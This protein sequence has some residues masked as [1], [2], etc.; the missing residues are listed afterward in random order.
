M[1]NRRHLAAEMAE[2]IN[3]KKACYLGRVSTLGQAKDSRHGLRSQRRAAYDYAQRNDLE[4]TA[5]YEDTISGVK[6]SREAFYR[7][8]AEADQY[9]AVIVYHLDRIGRDARVSH[10]M[11]HALRQAGLE[12]HTTNRGLVADDL[13]TDMEIAISAEER[14]SILKRTQA[15]LVAQARRGLLPNGI[16]TY[17]YT[18][19]SGTGRAAINPQEAPTVRRVFG[20]AGDGHGYRAIG[21][22]LNEAG[23]PSPNGAQWSHT[24]AAVI[25][26]NTAYKGE[27]QWRHR[28]GT[29]VI[30]VP[31]IITPE[32]WEKAQSKR[33]GPSP[34]LGFPLTGHLRCGLCGMAMSARLRRRYY[35]KKDGS[36]SEY[37]PYRYYRCN[38]RN[39]PQ[40]HC[41]QGIPYAPRV[42]RLVDAELR[43]LLSS[44][45]TI[46]DIVQLTRQSAPVDTRRLDELKAQ[47]E[48]LLEALRLGG[49][50]PEEFTSLRTEIREEMRALREPQEDGETPVEMIMEAARTLP[51][52]ELLEYANAV[53]VYTREEIRVTARL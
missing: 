9:Q 34:K 17:G 40:G 23:V 45:A 13:M 32:V 44:D 46:R 41:G 10:N 19:L 24:A 52:A 21:R 16:K 7:L 27:Y 51:L 5:D 42:E 35:R 29:Y 53:A 30:P 6:E 48:R 49:L 28:T 15:G 11:I 43:R 39:M 25:I 18:N 12:I 37:P 38:S 8:L 50:T 26:R 2:K 22:M 47:E 1:P 33:R 31:P 36:R 4:I 20:L 3:N 14:R